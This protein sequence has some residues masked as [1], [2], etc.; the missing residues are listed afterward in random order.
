M[1]DQRHFI[2]LINITLFL[3]REGLLQQLAYLLRKLIF[4]N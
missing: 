3:S 4:V 2:A 1:S